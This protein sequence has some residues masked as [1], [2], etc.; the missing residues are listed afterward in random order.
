M[1]DIMTRRQGGMGALALIGVV[2]MLLISGCATTPGR[3][4]L[5]L[6][7]SAPPASGPAAGL[8]ATPPQRIQEQSASE[9]CPDNVCDEFEI[10]EGICEQDCRGVDGWTEREG[11]QPHG[12]PQAQPQQQQQ[13]QQQALR[14][15]VISVEA[16]GAAYKTVSGKPTGWFT[17][18]QDADIMLA[19]IGFNDTGGPLLFNHPGEVATDGTRLFLAD[20]NNNRVL[21]WNTLPVG[22]TPPDLVLGQKDLTTNNPGTGSDQMNWPV[23]VSAAE[24]KLIVA[25][26]YNER[27][28]IWNSMPT[29][30]A[31]PA[32]LILQDQRGADPKAPSI[33]WP[34]GVWTDGRKL[35]VS[36]TQSASVLL[37]DSFP[38]GSGQQPD[39]V[40]TAGGEMGTPR[41]ITSDGNYLIVADHNAKVAGQGSEGQG[42]ASATFVWKSWPTSDRPADFILAGWRT[43]TFLPDGGLMLLST[44][45]YPPSVW[46]EPPAGA[47]DGPDLELTQPLGPGYQSLETGDGSDIAWAGGR[48]YLSLSNGNRIIVYD[49][50]P[51]SPTQEADF[52]IG[53]PDVGTNTLS[54][55]FFLT[56]PAVATDGKSLFASSDFE[57]AM[58]VWTSLP[59]ESNAPPDFVY[60]FPEDGAWDN[61]LWGDTLVLAGKKTVYLWK[62]LP[63]RGELPDVTYSGGIGS[64][65]FDDLA[66][67]ALDDRYLYL[68]DKEDIYVW[69][70]IPEGDAE[71][72]FIL[73][74]LGPGR[75]DSDGEHLVAII[76]HNHDVAVW[77][78]GELSASA[79]PS[80]VPV[81]G[82]SG[83]GG[84]VRFN[85]PGSATVRD[86]HLFVA[87]TGF[88]RV[89]VW[90]DVQ[91]ALE[92]KLP[93]VALGEDDLGD[94]RQEIGTDKLFWPA[95]LAFDGSFL[96]V[97]EFKFSGRILRYSV[98]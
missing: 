37:W 61:A 90:T 30:N 69:E 46:K 89:L 40:L 4:D 84:S 67:V 41:G 44:T 58:Y 22:N 83:T 86:S 68:A 49:S 52:A 56:N 27:I 88:G 38:T 80:V 20:R 73:S 10:R 59:D 8:N 54:T 48:L 39:L 15:Q 50:V 34:W 13:T 25:D 66:G 60:S 17:T 28:L 21:V 78:V 57:K 2:A 55:N 85:L 35:A 81:G 19:G 82:P 24:G 76:N 98:R 79:Q 65:R 18:G 23:G 97:A 75:L 72:A 74:G 77:E 9:K 63:L 29:R 5:S 62:G 93:D 11:G 43:G 51:D 91:D 36:S 12:S 26:T 95:T 47:D 3:R 6:D 71:P 70:G 92:G 33:K 7:P 45:H 16:T 14:Q 64:V 42:S 31:Q 94:V 32:D 96:W 53:A 1:P 87:D